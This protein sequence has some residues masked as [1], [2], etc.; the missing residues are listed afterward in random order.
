[1]KIGIVTHYYKSSNYGGNL[2]AFAL[3]H[4][5]SLM[6]YE[7]EQICYD[8]AYHQHRGLFKRLLSLSPRRFLLKLWAY[9]VRPFRK[10]SPPS[11]LSSMEERRRA[12]AAFNEGLIPHS[13]AVYNADT[14]GQASS[15]Y[16]IFITGSDQV[17]TRGAV[18][19]A[20][21][22]S[23]LPEGKPRFSYAASMAQKSLT[24]KE[25][26]VFCATLASYRGLSVREE[27]TLSLL[28]PLYAGQIVLSLDPTLLLSPSVWE[29]LCPP[30]M[31]EEKYLFCYFL[32][33]DK[34]E[35]ELALA[36]AKEKGLSVVTL[37]HLTGGFRKE[38]EGFGDRS[39]YDVSPLQ[40]LSLIR[41]ADA[42]FTDSFH[43]T[44]FSGIF[45]RPYF[46]FERE[47]NREAGA[48]LVTLFSLF[49]H[50]GRFCDS[51][52]KRTLSYLLSKEDPDYT[53]E[54]SALLDA[55]RA[56]EAY[57]LEMLRGVKGEA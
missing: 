12:I 17:F 33:K 32:G 29:E 25:E 9:A 4:A 8:S 55:R 21:L 3:C 51:E 15:L 46:T 43:A 50:K 31:V 45:K 54:M 11:F 6:G 52:E 57:L 53:N 40:L 49:G 39:L 26:K 56:S 1:M 47:G 34:K 22:L 16:D 24:K 5:L 7:S 20:Y 41:Y 42:V 10:K 28:S 36:Y 44:V 30:R 19:P 27:S 37:P 23:F 18:C 14:I 35:R 38:D 2:Q 48:R 13:T